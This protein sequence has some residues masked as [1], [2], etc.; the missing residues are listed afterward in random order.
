MEWRATSSRTS[1]VFSTIAWA[2]RLNHR[3]RHASG[4]STDASVRCRPSSACYSASSGWPSPAA[5]SCSPMASRSVTWKK[6]ER[7]DDEN[8][9]CVVVRG[10]CSCSGLGVDLSLTTGPR[11]LGR[12]ILSPHSVEV[13]SASRHSPRRSRALPLVFFIASLGSLPGL[14]RLLRVACHKVQMN[15]TYR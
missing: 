15:E 11:L 3:R 9:C 5:G 2:R 7:C 1:D 10:S 12:I 6:S 8:P 14:L 13:V 4:R